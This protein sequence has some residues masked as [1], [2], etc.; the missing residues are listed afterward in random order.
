MR[1]DDAMVIC[2]LK[3]A[4]PIKI[5]KKWEESLELDE[6]PKLE[7]LYKFVGETV[8][9]LCTLEANVACEQDTSNNKRMSETTRDA[10]V[11]RGNNNVRTLVTSS[12]SACPH[13]KGSHTIFKC[14]S[15][16]AL[17]VQQRWDFVR[18]TKLCV[19]CL[20]SHGDKCGFGHCKRCDR[21]HNTLLH[22][23]PK[24]STP[25]PET[26]TMPPSTHC[27]EENQRA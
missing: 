20:R 27:R 14:P 26:S 7:Q 12:A 24:T 9:R 16:G 18:A 5:R 3:R 8:F 6:L 4:L 11:R 19:N 1:V 10:K 25:K 13:C 15:F 21:H 17:T 22:A 23:D 2:I